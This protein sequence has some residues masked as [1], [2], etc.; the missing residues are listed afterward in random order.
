MALAVFA[1]VQLLDATGPA[2]VFSQATRI[3]APGYHVTLVGRSGATTSGLTLG[4][5]EAFAQHD[6]ELD[7]LM[8]AGGLGVRAAEHDAE[9]VDWVRAASAR[10]RRVTSVCTGAFL[11]ARAGLLDGR[12]ATTHWASCPELARRY[13]AVTVEPDRIFVRDGAIATSA[14]VTAGMDLALALV[15]EDLG[16]EVAIEVA[17]R[18]V[19]FVRRPGGQAQFGVRLAAH[20]VPGGWL[21]DLQAWIAE[22]VGADLSAADLARRAHVS[23]RTLARAFARELGTTP[24]AYVET[25]R[26]EQARR[27]LETGQEPLSAVAQAC[28]FGTCETMRRAFHRRLGVAPADYRR[29][30]ATTT[31][32]DDADRDRDLRAVH[33]A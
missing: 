22:H 15:E 19:L 1:D 23:V 30:F 20:P 21:G 27:R 16:A 33:R 7:T 6:G 25:V 8:V 31:G 29:R 9:L 17:R 26:V 13:P 32:G 24:A 14:G 2:E 11:L 3:A 18:L 4:P 5:V 28:G 10:A 12:R